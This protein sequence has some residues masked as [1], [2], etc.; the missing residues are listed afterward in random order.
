MSNQISPE[1][2][3]RNPAV[4]DEIR[5]DPLVHHVATPRW[6]NEVRATQARL[7][8][9]ATSLAVPTFMPVAGA[10][11][12]VD[13]GASIAFARA[14]GPTVELRVYDD[15]FHEIYLEPER[16][17]VI[18]DVVDWLTRRFGGTA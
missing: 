15:L 7:R 12:L 11:Q 4:W 18:G 2:V 16:D 5:N 10:D 14:A 17:R 8:V 9:S 13:A 6:F 1:L 3:T